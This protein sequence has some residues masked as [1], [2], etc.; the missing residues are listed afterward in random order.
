MDAEQGG[1]DLEVVLDAVMDLA[2]QSALA[3]ERFGHAALGL[4]DAVDRAREGIA[5]LADFASRAELIAR[6]ELVL[7]AGL[8]EVDAS[9]ERAQRPKQQAIDDPPADQR[10]ER[11]HDDGEQ[12]ERAFEGR[13]LRHG[14]DDERVDLTLGERDAVARA[15]VARGRDIPRHQHQPLAPVVKR[16]A[17]DAARVAPQRGAKFGHRQARGGA[18]PDDPS[19]DEQRTPVLRDPIFDFASRGARWLDNVAKIARHAS[20]RA[21]SVFNFEIVDDVGGDG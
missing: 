5:Q 13:H 6:H 7:G 3:L 2:D 10:G 15:T 9:L 4:V 1:D 20:D 17:G 12:D 21:G 8:I 16:R 18:A 19:A 14:E 11:P